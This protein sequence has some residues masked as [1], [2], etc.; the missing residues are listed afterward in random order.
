[1]RIPCGA[2]GATDD[3]QLCNWCGA[4]ADDARL[5]SGSGRSDRRQHLVHLW[6]ADGTVCVRHVRSGELRPGRLPRDGRHQTVLK[7][8]SSP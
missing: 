3:A 5:N 6:A 4:H 8:R 7:S 2:D 1:M